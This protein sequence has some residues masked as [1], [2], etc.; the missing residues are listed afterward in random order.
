MRGTLGLRP[1][2]RS[3]LLA[4]KPCIETF[5]KEGNKM[6]AEN[7]Y[8]KIDGKRLRTQ[9]EWRAEHEAEFQELCKIK[10]EAQKNFKRIMGTIK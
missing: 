10:S 9:D 2:K 7:R 1:A 4:T 3:T 5:I 8:P 6:F